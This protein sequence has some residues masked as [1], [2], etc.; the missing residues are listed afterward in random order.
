MITVADHEK[1]TIVQDDLIEG[2]FGNY[3]LGNV[4]PRFGNKAEVEANRQAALV[5]LTGERVVASSQLVTMVLTDE[6]G[7]VDLDAMNDA[8]AIPKTDGLIT[9]NPNIVISGNPADCSMVAMYGIAREGGP[10][11]AS[12]TSAGEPQS[13]MVTG[14]L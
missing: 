5:A 2:V 9:T 10:C 7:F 1:Y 8:N 12:F 11:W 6:P 4:D 14:R 3:R 13:K